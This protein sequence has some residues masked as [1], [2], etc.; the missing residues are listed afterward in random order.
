MKDIK[1]S[2]RALLTVILISLVFISSGTFFLVDIYGL[3]KGLFL[4]DF[5]SPPVVLMAVA[6]FSLV[7]KMNF[8]GFLKGAIRQVAPTALG[9][10]VIHP[11]VINRLGMIGVSSTSLTPFLSIPLV[12]ILVFLLSCLA[13]SVIRQIPYLRKTVS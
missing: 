12:S 6:V 2:S 9:I 3:D 13:I 10:Y 1:I 11:I 5:V 4:Y 7:R 8:P